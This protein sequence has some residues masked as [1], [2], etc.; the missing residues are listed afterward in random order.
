[1]ANSDGWMSDDVLNAKKRRER[2]PNRASILP[3]YKGEEGVE[4]AWPQ[5]AVDTYNAFTLPSD[6]LKGYNPTTED[7][8]DFA[9]GVGGVGLT[10]SAITKPDADLGMFLGAKAKNADLKKLAEANRMQE[11][12]APREDIWSK[13]GWWLKP[14]G[15]WAWEVSDDAFSFAPEVSDVLGKGEKV[16]SSQPKKVLQHPELFDNYPPTPPPTLEEVRAMSPGEFKQR[17]LSDNRGGEPIKAIGLEMGEDVNIGGLFYPN[18][19]ELSARGK[20]TE[21]LRKIALHEMQHAIQNAE[22]WKGAGANP[23][24]T[25]HMVNR[26]E[27]LAPPEWGEAKEIEKRILFYQEDKK[28]YLRHLKILQDE[29]ANIQAPKG[30]GGIFKRKDSGKIKNLQEKIEGVYGLLEYPTRMEKTLTERMKEIFS[31][32]DFQD[33]VSTFNE[34]RS[35][36]GKDPMDIYHSNEGEMIAN[37]TAQR[38]NMT[39]AERIATPPWKHFGDTVEYGEFF[40]TPIPPE[41]QAWTFQEIESFIT[42]YAQNPKGSLEDF[43]KQLKEAMNGRR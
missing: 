31:N 21:Q 25:S 18:N 41:R 42:N 16:I 27:R 2:D 12:G 29:L 4:L 8:I 3:L 36:F 9:L 22:D 39:E 40:N 1:M 5:W 24:W 14:D 43:N 38:M 13:T 32:K 19:K 20:S 26:L 33:F 6:T 37:I 35:R 17:I 28:D 10:T 30:G 7:T 23:E 15:E 34:F 11:A